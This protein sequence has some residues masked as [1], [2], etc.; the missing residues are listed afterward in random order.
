MGSTKKPNPDSEMESTEEEEQVDTVE[1]IGAPF[2]FEAKQDGMASL[3]PA[4][5]RKINA[6]KNLQL[7]VTN[8]DA[9]FY[10]EVHALEVKYMRLYYPYLDKRAEIVTG[11]Y[12]PTDEECKWEGETEEES[13]ITEESEQTNNVEKKTESDKKDEDVKGVPGFWLTIFKNV[14]MLAD[15]V[16]EHDEPILEC[17]EDIKVIM[18]EKD[19]MGFVLEFHF[20]INEYFTNS[21]LTKEYNMKCQPDHDHPFDFEGPEIFKCIG[22]SITWCKDKNVTVKTIKKKQKHKSRGSVRTVAKTVP[23]DSFFNFFNPPEY[24]TGEVADDIQNLLTSDFEIGHYLRER[25]VPF[26]VLLYTGEGLDE[27]EDFEEEEEEEDECSSEEESSEEE[28]AAKKGNAGARRRGGAGG[29]GGGRA[30]GRGPRHPSTND[31]SNEDEA[32]D[33]RG[34]RKGGNRASAGKGAKASSQQTP[35]NPAECKQQ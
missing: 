17:L 25:V 6:L 33:A 19:P 29:G 35:Q 1:K 27:E 21:V 26:A 15:M 16:Q 5:R 31:E 2:A 20:G 7:T 14:S 10:T 9:Q 4:V 28:T 3:P 18:L 11:R 23:T 34:G 22:C 8:L 24:P 32:K 12:E 30:G 13:A